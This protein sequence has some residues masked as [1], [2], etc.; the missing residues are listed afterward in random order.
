[1]AHNTLVLC[2]SNQIVNKLG[3][4]GLVASVLPYAPAAGKDAKLENLRDVPLS[5]NFAAGAR[6]SSPLKSN[7]QRQ[8]GCY[9]A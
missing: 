8:G 1:M 7:E 9:I 6:A 3:T 5:G 4:G 2:G